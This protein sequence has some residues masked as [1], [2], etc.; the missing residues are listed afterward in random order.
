MA[1]ARRAVDRHAGVHQPLARRIDIV[2]PVG[3]M[4]EITATRI[5]FGRAA[6]DGR[7]IIGQLDLRH[8][9]L[10]G[11]GEKDQGEA[12][13]LVIETAGFLQPDQL[14]ERSE[15]HTSE[16][17]SLMRI[18]YAVYCLKKKKIPPTHNNQN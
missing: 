1:V 4:P 15:E 8:V 10:S 13:D 18:S 2:D 5:F 6:V 16:L 7:P 14:E 17:Q 11:S 3:E 12:A 9:A